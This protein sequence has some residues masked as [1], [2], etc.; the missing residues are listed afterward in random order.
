MKSIFTLTLVCFISILNS[1][2]Q[3]CFEE[4]F[5]DPDA[6]CSFI[7]DPVC[8]C[9]QQEYSNSC[10]ALNSGISSW[11]EGPCSN[12]CLTDMIITS[13]FTGGFGTDDIPQS[14]AEETYCFTYGLTLPIGDNPSIA[15]SSSDGQTSDLAEAC[16]SFQTISNGEPVNE[17][18]T[19]TLSVTAGNCTF[20]S[21]VKVQPGTSGGDECLDLVDVDFGDCEAILGV[22]VINNSCVAISGCSTIGSDNVD[23][24]EYFFQSYEDCSEACGSCINPNQI[25]LEV[26]CPT[27]AIPVCGCDGLTYNNSCEAEN[28]FGVTSYTE[29]PCELQ[30]AEPCDDLAG[31]DF[32]ECDAIIGIGMLNGLCSVI[33]GCVT[34]VDGVD[35]SD[36]FFDSMFD[37]VEC[38]QN[39][40]I[41]PQQIDPNYGCDDVFDPV[42][43]C[44]SLTYTNSCEAIINGVT[45]YQD[46]PCVFENAEPCDD[47]SGVDFGPCDAVIGIGMLNGLCTEISG[48]DVNIGGVNYSDAFFDSIFDCVEC[49]QDE[50]FNPQQ[51]NPNYGCD[52]NY[53]PVCGCDSVTYSN[54]CVAITSGVTSWDDG[55]CSTNSVN[56]ENE[57]T[58]FN[59]FPIP[60]SDKVTLQF[61]E[62]LSAEIYIIDESGREIDNYLL[63]SEKVLHMD[64]ALIANG[65]YM[66]MSRSNS[67]TEC[68]ERI[69]VLH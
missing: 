25:D 69:V 33:S 66:I 53:D 8:G 18:Y 58:S 12:G 52:T 37:C 54:S 21:N 47:L 56:S 46:G 57:G 44:D 39:E 49:D 34:T 42:C 22:S 60:A 55:E 65:T 67:K 28:Y 27:V 38:G 61:R 9:N 19:I 41:N 1:Q 16:F 50:C 15:W 5:F 26:I 48:C 6:F 24:S 17:E 40:C 3:E 68:L 31:V 45:A 62:P 35:Y 13:E 63:N 2:V 11:T 29:G 43:G 30:N 59:I 14:Y 4:C 10:I 36:A 7:F 32:G 64:V 23:Y 51:V 20:V